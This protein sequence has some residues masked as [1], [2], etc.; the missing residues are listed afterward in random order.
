MGHQMPTRTDELP[1]V[2]RRMAAGQMLAQG[3]SIP[4]VVEALRMSADTVRRYKAILDRGGLEALKQVSVGG[5]TAALDEDALRWLAAAL[6]GSARE[7]GFPT[8][9][10]T[11][12]RVREVIA[13]RFGTKYSR[14]HTWQIVTNLGLSHRLSKSTR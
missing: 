4:E 9:A 13:T 7:H 6:Q 3:A 10:W 8:D 14:V 12:A 1:S 11:N 5:R 2:V